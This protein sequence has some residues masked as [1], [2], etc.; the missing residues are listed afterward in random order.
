MDIGEVAKKS[1]LS[2]S[3]LRYYEEIGLIQSNDRKGLR[4]Q[5]PA[6]VLDILALITLAKEA[7]FQLEELSVLFSKKGGAPIINRV[8]LR[9]KATEIEEKIKKL[10]AAR[11]GLI[12]A[13]E[14][15]APSHFECPKFQRLLALAT[16]R[17]I[18]R[19]KSKK[20]KD[21]K[22]RKEAYNQ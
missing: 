2:T 4:R 22:S 3:A 14:C 8:E 17:Q 9:H 18:K 5:Y 15:R 20:F 19:K 12:H 6:N 13:S 1:G 10:E 7:G 16:V 21:S 11:K